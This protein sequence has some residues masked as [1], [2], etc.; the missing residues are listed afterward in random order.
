MGVHGVP[1]RCFIME[2]PLGTDDSEVSHV[3]Y[4]KKPPYVEMLKKLFAPPRMDPQL[5]KFGCLLK[6]VTT[7]H[8]IHV[9]V[10][11]FQCTFFFSKFIFPGNTIG[12]I[13]SISLSFVFPCVSQFFSRFFVRF[14]CL[15]TKIPPLLWPHLVLAPIVG[16]VPARRRRVC[17]P[18]AVFLG[19]I[20]VRYTYTYTYT[21]TYIYIYI[22]T[23]TYIY[24]YIH[25]YVA[26][27]ASIPVHICT[28]VIHG[29]YV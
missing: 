17:L 29:I 18:T 1:Y 15:P 24:T 4:V 14:P 7:S 5:T 20:Y 21:Y 13:V 11:I 26:I 25:T 22:Y 9:S 23:Y 2:H 27:Y 16:K 19:Y 6:R 10:G 8:T 3:G 12:I 28:Y